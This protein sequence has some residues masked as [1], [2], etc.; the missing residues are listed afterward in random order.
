MSEKGAEVAKGNDLP[1]EIWNILVWVE[2]VTGDQ[3]CHGGDVSRLMTV[4]LVV[5][6]VYIKGKDKRDEG[7]RMVIVERHAKVSAIGS[8]QMTMHDVLI[9]FTSWTC[10][11]EQHH[12][13]L[14]Q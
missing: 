5:L 6:V 12:I 3:V 8:T 7:S 14:K 2:F 4:S 9:L 11:A 13:T 10:L 1:T